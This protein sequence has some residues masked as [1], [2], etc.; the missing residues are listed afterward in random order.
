MR[1]GTVLGG[2]GGGT[3]QGR[4]GV[5]MEVGKVGEGVLGEERCLRVGG[6]ERIRD[7]VTGAGR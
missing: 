5:W 1:D 2:G 3:V 6:G 7:V 4:V